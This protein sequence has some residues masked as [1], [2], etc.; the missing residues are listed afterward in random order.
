MIEEM[1]MPTPCQHCGEWFD[2]ND[3]CGSEKWYPGT[4]ICVG[5]REKEKEEIERDEEIEEIKTL[6]S[7]AEFDVKE[8]RGQLREMGV[9]LPE[10]DIFITGDLWEDYSEKEP[11]IDGAY[12]VYGLVNWGTE[13]ERKQQ[14]TAYW[15]QQNKRFVDREGEDLVLIDEGVQY[16]LNS[17]LIPDPK[18]EQV[19]LYDIL[20]LNKMDR[21]CLDKTALDIGLNPECISKQK[22]IYKVLDQQLQISKT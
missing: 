8:Y 11:T 15:D 21:E 20:E 4:V 6:L 14:F 3:G 17:L 18:T 22:L 2:L 1:D 9:I 5:C 16:W 7:E 13:F 19:L 10:S 12:I